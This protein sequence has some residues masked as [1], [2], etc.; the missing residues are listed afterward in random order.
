MEDLIIAKLEW[1]KLGG[2]A[3]QLEDVAALL[4]MAEDRVETPYL[5][6]WDTELGLEHDLRAARKASMVE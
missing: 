2:S 6:H 5:D 3:R 4:A 1:A